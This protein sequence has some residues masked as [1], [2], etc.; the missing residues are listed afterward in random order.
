MAFNHGYKVYI[1]ETA[2][3]ADLEQAALE[4]LVWVEVKNVGT[5]P[6]RGR[7]QAELT[8]PTLSHG[9][10][11]GKGPIDFGSGDFEVSRKGTNEGRDAMVAAAA[12]ELTYMMKLVA[13]DAVSGFTATTEYLRGAIS[14]PLAPGGGPDGTNIN[15]FSFYNEMYLEV[16]PEAIGS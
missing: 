6:D 3:P 16:A 7:T 9:V 11:K 8:F 12:T 5:L 1:C 10:I 2:Q 4:A 13:P 14:G 15:R